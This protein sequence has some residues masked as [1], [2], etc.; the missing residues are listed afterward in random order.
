MPSFKSSP[1]YFLADAMIDSSAIQLVPSFFASEHPPHRENN[2]QKLT[3]ENQNERLLIEYAFSGSRSSVNRWRKS[4]VVSGN[5]LYD[6]GKII[7][8]FRFTQ[9]PILKISG[10]FSWQD[11]STASVPEPF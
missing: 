7:C 4:V 3:N 10:G 2:H 1:R 8:R 5:I 11:I 9:H 6:I